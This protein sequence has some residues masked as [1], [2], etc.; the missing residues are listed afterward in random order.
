MG[1]G[2]VIAGEIE[3][4]E[5][6]RPLAPQQPSIYLR[7][8]KLATAA[9]CLMIVGFLVFN[10]RIVKNIESTS[11]VTDVYYSPA[12]ALVKR[13]QDQLSVH[14]ATETDN[15]IAMLRTA[16]L[17]EPNHFNARLSLSFALS[18]KATKFG[19]DNS[20]KKEAEGIARTLIDERPD[21]SNAWSALGYTL[22]SHGRPNEALAAYQQAYMLNPKNAPALSSAAHILL[23]RGEFQQALMLELRAQKSGGSSRYAEIQIAQV[24]E[25]ISHPSAKLWQEKALMLNPGQTVVLSEVAKSYLRQGK[26]KLALDLLSQYEDN[27]RSAPQILQLRG[28]VL[29]TLGRI[30]EA[31]KVL[32]TAGWRGYSDIA[33]LSAISGDASLAEEF[34]SESKLLKMSADPDPEFR[35]QLAEVSAAQNQD[36]RALKLVA[37]AINLGWRDIN[38]LKRSPF[39][40]TLMKSA[41][42]TA[43]RTTNS[44]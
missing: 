2:Y 22:S 37:E 38:W 6:K 43:T 19:G 29:I 35:I 5:N 4:I 24:L 20:K 27:N 40:K 15:A 8:G 1:S 34:F 30:D 41:Q 44:S 21:S 12:S 13:A 23:L 28:R 33:A 39:L 25:L 11:N 18:T 3:Y 10:A 36:Q 14:Q 31:K 7:K 26:P 16:L 9:V 17:E 32:R 42:G